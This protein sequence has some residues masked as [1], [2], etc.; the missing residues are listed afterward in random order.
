VVSGAAA[1]LCGRINWTGA[2]VG[3]HVIGAAG[4]QRRSTSAARSAVRLAHPDDM[5]NLV[6]PALAAEHGR[7]SDR[8]HKRPLESM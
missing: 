6:P 4:S 2:A 5:M 3:Q 8:V 1:W 7:M